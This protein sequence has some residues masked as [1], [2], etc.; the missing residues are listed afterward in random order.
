MSSGKI[1]GSEQ[2]C[3]QLHPSMSLR[4]ASRV[5]WRAAQAVAARARQP[6]SRPTPMPGAAK[7]GVAAQ[8]AQG[9]KAGGGV[10]AEK[11]VAAETTLR[12]RRRRRAEKDDN[13]MHLVCWGP[14]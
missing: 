11:A 9:G 2:Q 14:N 1:T 13:V 3:L 5:A 4:Y 7:P 10:S 8:R 12:R 6:P